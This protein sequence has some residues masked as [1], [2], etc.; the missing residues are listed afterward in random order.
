MSGEERERFEDYL[1][2]ETFIEALQ[3]GR[4]AHLPQ[5]VTP[6]QAGVYHIV[7]L[8]HSIFPKALEPRPAFAAVLLQVLL[9]QELR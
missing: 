6:D 1:E 4:I 3:A 8:F 9:E 2:L 7:I 5:D